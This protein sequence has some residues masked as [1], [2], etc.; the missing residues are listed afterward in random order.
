MMQKKVLDKT[1]EQWIKEKPVLSELM[2]YMPVVWING[3]L[4]D[5]ENATYNNLELDWKD[6]LEAEQRWIRFAPLM[7]KLFPETA[8]QKG[9]IE[10]DLV[11]LTN[12]K[13][14]IRNTYGTDI[15]GRMFLK[16]DNDLPVAGSIK[17][18]GGIYEVLKHAEQL[19]ISHRMLIEDQDYSVL[20]D[21]KF[22]EFF[23]KYSLAVGST[24]NLGLSIG[25]MGSALGFKVTVH[26]SADAK[27]WK[28]DLLRSKGVTVIEYE[29]D[30]SEAVAEGRR[31]ALQDAMCY[32]VDDEHS[33]DLFL[34]Y[35]A[36]AIRLKRQ[37]EEKNIKV[38]KQNPLFVYLPCGVGGAPGG[39]CFGLKQIYKDD[40]HCFFAEP[41]HSPCMLL[42]LATGEND[43][44]SVQDFG[45]DNITE[46]DGLA[47]G[48]PSGFVGKVMK[49]LLSGVY[50]IEDD[51][52]YK[53]LALLKDSENIEIEPSAAASLM[54]PMVMK[55]EKYKSN[56]TH[57]AWATGG[58]FVPANLKRDFYEKGKSLLN[59]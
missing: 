58:S 33:K 5:R 36:A 11:E 9:I 15:D 51:E 46:G 10:S 31:L 41:T 28:K 23:S 4:R 22:K 29:S 48:R 21:A 59:K 24:G 19:A 30:Y 25:I 27:Q 2:A 16:C 43:N 6:V 50:T 17:A 45:I 38:D 49:N 53:L 18:R 56:A 7:V 57:I 1:L 54:G 39:I 42:G 47:V 8:P 13:E 44:L 55:K 34:G 26:M 35:S 3:D 52:L 20:A 37:L 32:F 12:M 14:E 40:V